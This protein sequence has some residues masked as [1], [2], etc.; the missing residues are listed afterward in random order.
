MLKRFKRLLREIRRNSILQ[1]RYKGFFVF[2]ILMM[3]VLS[4]TSLLNARVGGGHGYSGKG[5]GGSGGSGGGDGII[6]LVHL[7]FRYP[8]IGIPIVVIVIFFYL[9]SKSK[10]PQPQQTYSSIKSTI[11]MLPLASKQRDASVS[12]LQKKDPNFSLPLFLDFAQLLYINIFQMAGKHQLDKMKV[13]LAPSL[14]E[15][16]ENNCRSI[17]EIKDIIIGSCSIV[18]IDL[19]NQEEDLIALTFETNYAV[20]AAENQKTSIYTYYEYAKW[21][22]AR[23]K[24]IISKGPGEMNRIGC[25]QCGGS[26]DDNPE[27]K[28]SYCGHEFHNGV[29]TWYVKSI[30]LLDQTLKSP[31]IS[32]GYAVEK[33]T[34][35]PTL[36][37][38]E[39]QQRFIDFKNK[40]PD[41]DE[42]QFTQRAIYIFKNLQ[43]AW[44]TQKWE[45]ARPYETDHLFQ[46]HL[47]WINLYKKERV[48]NVLKDIQVSKVQLVKIRSDAYYDALTVR[49]Y[50]AMID[51]TETIGGNLMGGDPKHSRPFSEYWTFIRRAGVKGTDKKTDQCPNCGN[52]LKIGMVGKCEYCGSKITTGEFHWVLSMIEQDDGYTG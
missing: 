44:T 36:F 5:G 40:Y 30:T 28:C 38:P 7:I 42:S 47:Y 37:Q 11:T 17:Q 48:R 43:Q 33:G 41:F 15:K 51:Y 8:K 22:L 20:K 2:L 34:Q 27:G 12:Q 18:G 31:E 46:T 13:Y 39:F 29:I 21:I 24:G 52:T 23:K 6:F 49:I 9:R 1:E 26:L 4:F 50:A 25:P 10:N 35:L 32:G 3:V 19:V 16:M 14:L 45:L